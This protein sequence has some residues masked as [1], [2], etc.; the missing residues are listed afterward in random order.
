MFRDLWKWLN[1]QYS[2]KNFINSKVFLFYCRI[3]CRH[4]RTGTA[5]TGLSLSFPISVKPSRV[6]F[7]RGGILWEPTM[8]QSTERVAVRLLTSSRTLCHCSLKRKAKG[9]KTTVCLPASS[10]TKVN[11][12]DSDSPLSLTDSCSLPFT[13]CICQ[14]FQLLWMVLPLMRST[15]TNVNSSGSPRG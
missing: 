10:D 2:C 11:S 12:T 15:A 4:K 7:C 5:I 6:T 9:P 8:T 1:S 13:S 14:I 3:Q